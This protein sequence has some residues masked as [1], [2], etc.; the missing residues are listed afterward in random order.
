MMLV[1]MSVRDF[2]MPK[3]RKERSLHKATPYTSNIPLESPEDIKEWDEARCPVCI[4]HPH[5]AVLLICSSHDKGCRPYMCDTSYR[6]SNCLDQFC[7]S[8]SETSSSTPPPQQEETQLPT[9]ELVVGDTTLADSESESS[10]ATPRRCENQVKSKMVCP[11]CRGD[12][13]KWTIVEPA[14]RFM[15]AKPRSCSC[16]TCTFTGTYK[17]LRTHARVDHPTVRPSVADPERERNWRRMER[18]RDFEDLLTT[19]QSSF[20]VEEMSGEEILPIGDGHLLTVLLFIQVIHP[21]GSS[22]NPLRLVRARR[23][24][25]ATSIRLRSTRLWGETHDVENGSVSSSREENNNDESDGGSA[26]P[27]RRRRVYRPSTPD[28]DEP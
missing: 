25:P 22:S 12:I 28:D 21:G 8:F 9:S 4:E 17:D 19:I 10:A 6:H 13:M 23:T 14:R 18:E 26:P 1:L 11:L 24:R 2:D 7:K 3:E 27:A 16:E 5:N 15:D 20:G